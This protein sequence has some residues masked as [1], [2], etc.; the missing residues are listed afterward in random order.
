M[1]MRKFLYILTVATI[2]ASSAA[3]AQDKGT[4][5]A[6]QSEFG[7]SNCKL[8]TTGR[9]QYFVLEP[10]FQL[11][12]EG[13]DTKLQITVLNETKTVDGIITRVVEE[14]EWE[15]G[16]LYEISRNYFA[17]CE[18]T[19]DVFYFGEDVDFYKN[20]KVVKHEGSWLAGNEG[21][22]AGLIMPGTPKVG[23]KY[24][25]EIAPKVA[26]DRAEIVSLD[27]TCKTPAGTFSKCLKVKEGTALNIIEEEYKY[28]AP[29]I[30]LIQDE[31]LVLTKHGIV[32]DGK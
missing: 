20:G 3:C 23:M 2:F 19:K 6:W 28:Y 9:N 18:R 13:D 17:M 5:S 27:E 21:N 1:I 11:V 30:G 14:K 29:G 31:D 4:N 32:S 16:K 7:I 8:L 25:Q 12:L 26:M 10:G 22:K 15:D 24:Y